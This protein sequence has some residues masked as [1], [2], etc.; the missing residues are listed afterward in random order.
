MKTSILTISAY[1]LRAAFAP[2][3]ALVLCHILC[4]ST[5]SGQTTKN[6]ADGT[7]V[8]SGHTMGTTY[9]IKVV[10][11]PGESGK[12]DDAIEDRLARING[13]MSTFL[14][15]SELS[16]FNQHL[17]TKPFAVSA[18]TA[19]VVDEAIRISSLTGGAYDI[20]IG[21]LVNLWGFGY[22]KKT[23]QIPPPA[24]ITATL[25]QIGSHHLKVTTMPPTLAKSLP[26]LELD[27]SSIAKGFGV[28]SVGELL[29]EA[30][31][32]RYMVEIGGEVRTRGLNQRGQPWVIAIESPIANIRKV[33]R[34]VRLQ[35]MAMATSGDYRNYFERDGRRYSHIIDPRSGLPISHRLASVT[36]L[37]SD[38]LRADAFATA[39]FVLGE[40]EG[41]K[42][43]ER[44]K[45][46]AVF[47]VKSDKDQGFEE[48]PTS[49]FQNHYRF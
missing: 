43:A 29:E 40:T 45:L 2:T 25:K 1:R 19:R 16:R 36:V 23:E 42:L 12:L 8:Y 4:L 27:L 28:D 11:A 26:T 20:T 7:R 35:N 32:N 48:K 17:S 37:A 9:T 30:K 38:C 6:L 39:L 47:I 15:D 21:P 14:P 34:I 41:F 33:Q 10:Q 18:E 5:A 46:A 44:E 22:G 3:L 24:K 49:A 31:I 13:L